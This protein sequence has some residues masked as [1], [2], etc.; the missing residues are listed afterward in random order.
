MICHFSGEGASLGVVVVI[1]VGTGAMNINRQMT[2][3]K[4][5]AAA[6]GGLHPMNQTTND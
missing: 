1:S 4:V 3:G 2:E 6:N 5:N